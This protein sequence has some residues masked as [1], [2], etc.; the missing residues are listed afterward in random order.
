MPCARSK[1]VK[2]LD[3]LKAADLDG[4]GVISRSEFLAHMVKAGAAAKA[5]RRSWLLSLLLLSG[6]V[7]VLIVTLTLVDAAADYV[8]RDMDKVRTPQAA[9]PPI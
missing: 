5:E 7:V 8:M 2:L 1:L 6:L 4:D 9:P 3:E